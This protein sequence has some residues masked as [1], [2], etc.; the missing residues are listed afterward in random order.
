[1]GLQLR[2]HESVLYPTPYMEEEAHPFIITNQR[3][4][5]KVDGA[6]R[7]LETRA[8]ESVGRGQARPL[9]PLGL[10]LLCL[11]LPGFGVGAYLYISVWAM[12]AAP[13]KALWQAPPEAPPEG[14]DP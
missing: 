3:L 10:V 12:K 8:I 2:Q 9:F 14:V 1:M 4:V 5:Q 11:G 7:Q 6:E 13:W